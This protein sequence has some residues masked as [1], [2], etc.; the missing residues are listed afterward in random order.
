MRTFKSVLALVLALTLLLGCFGTA[1]A[2]KKT[3]ITDI[4]GTKTSATT[5]DKSVKREVLAG[6]QS[7]EFKA[8]NTYKYADDEIVRAIIILEGEC[9]SDVAEAGS[10][11]AAAQRVKLINEHN[12]V[13]K[14]MT[15]IDFEMKYE[16]TTLLNGFSCDVAYGDLEAIAAIEGVKAVHIANHYA[17]PKLDVKTQ[18][19]MPNANNITGNANSTYDGYDGAGI[20]VAVL[21]TGLN[22]THEAFQDSI[23]M[24]AEYGLLTEADIAAA[25]ASLNGKGVY[26][27]A[28]IPFAYDYAEQDNDVTDYNGHGTHVSGIVGGYTIVEMEDGLYY[29]FVGGAPLAQILSMK[30]FMD[31]GG[32]TSSD[33]YFDAL[34]DAYNLGVDVVN[35]S[36]GA[37]NGFTYDASL[38]DE[39]FANIYEKMANAGIIMSVAAGNEYSMAEFSTMGYIG[40]EYTDF[41]TVA[42]PSTYLGNISI[43]SVEN[44]AY[45]SIALTVDGINFGYIDSATA[46]EDMW[47]TTFGDTTAEFAVVVNAEG[48]IANGTESDYA[49]NDVTGKIAVVSRGDITFEEKVEFAAKAG[50]IGCIVVNNEEGRISMSIETFE[51]P[52]VSVE[53]S[54]LEIFMNA[55]EKTITSSTKLAMV[56]NSNGLLMSEFSNWG[57]TPMLTLAPTITSVGGYVYSAYIGAD[58]EYIV[59]SG[60]SMAAPNAS[61][62]YANVLSAIYQ[63]TEGITKQEAAELAKSLMASTAY[64]LSDSEG[65]PFSPRKQGAG[66][67]DSYTSIYS[68]LE[69]AYIV[70]PLKE[71]GDDAEKTGVYEFSVTLKNDGEYEL[72]YTDFQAVVL[73]DYIANL[74]SD[75]SYAIIGNTL[76]SDYCEFDATFLCGGEEITEIYLAPGEEISVDV[77]IKLNDTQKAFFDK[78]YENGAFVEGYVIFNE[79][80]EGEAWSQLHA[81]FLAYYGDWAQASALEAIN[82]MDLMD[83]MYYLYNIPV[84]DEGNTYADYGYSVYDL[85][86]AMFGDLYTDASMAYLYDS[87]YEEA[88][89]YLGA[90]LLDTKNTEYMREHIAISTPASDGSYYYADSF[91]LSPSL[92]RNTRHIVMTVT[93][94]ETGEVYMV[95]DTEYIPKSAFD[96]EEE[97]WTNFSMFMWDGTDKE[98]NYVPSG[99]VANV[100]FDIQLPWG[101]DEDLWEEDAWTF[102]C[103]VDYTAPVL[104]SI[105]YDEEA[106]TLT[107]TASDENYLAGIYLADSNYKILDA[108]TFSSDKKGES[109][110]ATFDVSA[111]NAF[112]VT[113]I[114]YATNEIE[115]WTVPTGA[116]EPA[117]VILNT[118]YGAETIE[119]TTGTMFTFSAPEAVEGY[120]FVMW[121]T[122]KVEKATEEEV[123]AIPEPWYDAGDSFLIIEPEYTFYAL[124]AAI[125]ITQ[126]DKTCYY[127]DYGT[128]FE[129]DWAICG[130]NVNAE[131]TNYV[132]DDPYALDAEGNTIRIADFEDAEIDS[133]YVQ[134][135]TNEDAIRFTVELVGDGIY[136]LKN[137]ANGK[138]LATD[139]EFNMLF[140]DEVTDFAKWYLLADAHFTVPT[141]YGNTDAVLVH[142]YYASGEIEIMDNSKPCLGSYYPT[143]V[144][145]TFFYRATNEIETALYYTT[146]ISVEHV[147]PSAQFTDIDTNRYYH[148][149]VDYMVAN[150]YMKGLSDTKFG[151]NDT[152]TRAMV[153]TV[154]YRIAGSPEIS[155]PASFTD[156]AEGK[157]YSDAIAWAEAEGV[158]KGV[159]ETEF[160]PMANVTRE[161][162]ATILYR[163]IG[164]EAAD[165]DMSA[166]GDAGKISNYAKEAMSWAISAGIFKGDNE[167]NLN[168]T[169]NATRAE[170]ATM[171]YRFLK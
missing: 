110:T 106:K 93:D 87:E 74:S 20:V 91:Y 90:N 151:P 66:L 68:Y 127:L 21:D 16:F 73:Y 3:Q 97:V 18:T 142:D 58:D 88:V 33:I 131:G 11:K 171:M 99:T 2:A 30:I 28:K 137:A 113:A 19:K 54:A 117:K 31:A 143:D 6:F 59:N 46:E 27:N 45:P 26:L 43:A 168:P 116:G 41:G 37:Q 34:E 38:E 146:E 150:G 56:E 65:Y 109:F 124:Y 155:A 78:Y 1:F 104:E 120:E 9:E 154:L 53:L 60:T 77:S 61:A 138:Y 76:T 8:L 86:I 12:A 112:Y 128:G 79:Y 29:D 121:I 157:W 96:E 39:Y 114:D 69:S 71:L 82:S 147:C 161:Q 107:V 72:Y 108:A 119:T 75:P 166:F 167:G 92:L 153:V 156:V 160:A 89:T 49:T 152:L 13:R 135:F 129:G 115:E 84:D 125:E 162:I 23:G 44:I 140:V 42:A 102:D 85:A 40:P 83:A 22:T 100:T 169:N 95:D 81:T 123:E 5:S 111:Y 163:Y 50:A 62:T 122:E 98:G 36:I 103:T 141:N 55:E 132:I 134:F 67:A 101:V 64:I 17:E 159:S 130:W 136:T 170:F 70:D 15:G 47:L 10:E 51:I 25:Q 4:A 139:A 126:S 149:A 118:P 164:A 63:E 52:A 144:F 48:K 32:G 7:E 94:A 148:D 145:A 14:A 133:E 165:V 57:T 35:M 80:F 158:V 105:V 24:C